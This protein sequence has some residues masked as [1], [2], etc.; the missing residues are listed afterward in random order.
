MAAG[1]AATD[2]VGVGQFVGVLVFAGGKFD[3]GFTFMAVLMIMVVVMAVMVIVM[4]IVAM[5][6]MLMRVLRTPGAPHHP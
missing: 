5:V 3:G 2:V 1:K 6:V 4:M